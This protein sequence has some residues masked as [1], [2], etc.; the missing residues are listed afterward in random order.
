MELNKVKYPEIASQLI[1][2]QKADRALRDKLI[3][4]GTLGDGYHREMAA[5]HEL[6]AVK[7]QEIIDQIGYPTIDKVG[8]E[9][10]EAC[11]LIIQHAISKPSFM[12][13][14]LGLLEQAVRENRANPIHLAYLSDRIAVHEGIPQLYG[15][16][17]DWDEA[18]NLSPQACDDLVKLNK[19]RKAIG[20][21]TLEEQ[22]MIIRQRAKKEGQ[23]PPPDLQKRKDE[24]EQWRKAVGWKK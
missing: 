23:S 15:T 14:C 2:Y 18:G 12:K 8:S 20:L 9:A 21:N 13:N 11:W 16:Q 6:H 22:T 24:I 7:L 10:H 5:L 4:E 1:R 17:F 19:R 3:Q